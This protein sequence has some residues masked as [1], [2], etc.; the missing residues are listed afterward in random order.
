[1]PFCLAAHQPAGGPCAAPGLDEDHL[2]GFVGVVVGHY[3]L[4]PSSLDIIPMKNVPAPF[5]PAH[6]YEEQ[7]P[8]GRAGNRQQIKVNLQLFPLRL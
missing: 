4:P 2:I 1:M 5:Q 6:P 8:G 7:K 3:P